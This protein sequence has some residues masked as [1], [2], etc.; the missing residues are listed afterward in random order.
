MP[1]SWARLQR[2]S[3]ETEPPRCVCSSASPSI[4]RVY[5][6]APLDLPTMKGGIV[7]PYSWS[8]WG[9]VVEHAEL[10]ADALRRLGVETRT[11]MGN[12]PV[13]SF[14]RAL[15]PRLG[16]GGSRPP[17]PPG[18]GRLAAARRH[19]RRP[20]GDRPRERL[21]PEHRAQP[22]DRREDRAD[23]RA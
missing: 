2:M 12:D 19:P 18:P 21:A 4:R 17:P 11:I 3:D 9:A 6:R 15:H 14:T 13:G 16:R 22:A 23:A 20:L 5:V 7:A 8:F 1:C 10:Q